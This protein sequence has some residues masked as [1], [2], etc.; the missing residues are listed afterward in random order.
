MR[1]FTILGYF[2]PNSLYTGEIAEILKFFKNRSTSNASTATR[3]SQ[4]HTNVYIH[5]KAL[6]WRC[7]ETQKKLRKVLQKGTKATKPTLL[8]KNGQNRLNPPLV[9]KAFL[10]AQK[11]WLGATFFK[12]FFFRNEKFPKVTFYQKT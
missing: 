7:F 9:K 10:R 1:F 12:E 4:T 3:T 2:K 5:G 6:L 8:G 11:G